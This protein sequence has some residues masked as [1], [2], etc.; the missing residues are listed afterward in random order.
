MFRGARGGGAVL[1]LSE[2][3]CWRGGEREEGREGGHNAARPPPHC[4]LRH[5]GVELRANFKSI[6]HICHLEEVAFVQ[7]LTKE[8]IHLPLSC[9]QGGRDFGWNAGHLSMTI[10]VGTS[11]YP[12]RGTPLFLGLE[13][14]D[15]RDLKVRRV[16]EQFF[17]N[18]AMF[19]RMAY[20]VS[21]TGR[22]SPTATPESKKGSPKVNFPSKQW[23]S[24]V[25]S[26]NIGALE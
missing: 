26:A 13:M 7:E 17:E 2:S 20:L 23:F 14:K 5:P 3:H 15:L 4:G 8:T 24:K 18:I 12:Y 25:E 11:L 10:S 21:V 6:C 1:R 9:L 16:A 22:Y 19:R